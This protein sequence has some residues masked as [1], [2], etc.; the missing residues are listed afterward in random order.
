MNTTLRPLE[1]KGMF[2]IPPKDEV[3]ECPY[4]G[5]HPNEIDEY[6]TAAKE[7]GITPLEYVKLE[8]NTYCQYTGCFVCSSCY[9]NIGTPTLDKLHSAFP[10]FRMDVAPLEGQ[11]NQALVKYRLGE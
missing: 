4:C 9:V 10:Y 5:K 6:I 7:E 3:I 1:A 11:N 2:P 8:E